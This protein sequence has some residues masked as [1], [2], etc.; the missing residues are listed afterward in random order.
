MKNGV[1]WK[2][3]CDMAYKAVMNSL[4]IGVVTAKMLE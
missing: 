3:K 2:L 1:F 4:D